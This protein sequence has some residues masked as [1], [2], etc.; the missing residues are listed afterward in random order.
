MDKQVGKT[1]IVLTAE[2]L[3]RFAE[4]DSILHEPF[5]IGDKLRRCGKCGQII[6]S[7]LI[8]DEVCPNGSRHAFESIPVLTE[9]DIHV[10]HLGSKADQKR[11]KLAGQIGATVTA[12]SLFAVITIIIILTYVY[13]KKVDL[14]PPF[15]VLKKG[16]VK[17]FTVD[18]VNGM[19]YVLTKINDFFS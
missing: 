6:R 17:F 13:I 1:E 14:E 19:N 11:S 2:L 4:Y 9:E 10:I 3:K 16:I 7:E 12:F 18:F 15:L 5:K 8:V